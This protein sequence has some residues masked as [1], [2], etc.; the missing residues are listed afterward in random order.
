MTYNP[1]GGPWVAM[2]GTYTTFAEL[3]AATGYTPGT[4]AFA[5]DCGPVYS[6]GSNWHPAYSNLVY[7][8]GNTGTTPAP[9]CSKGFTQSW[10][11][12]GSVTWGAPTNTT[13]LNIGDMLTLAVQKDANGTARTTAWNAI[14]RNA[15]TIASTSTSGAKATFV[16][17]WDGT[18]WQYIGG[19]TA[20]A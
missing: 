10:T 13:G 1:K 19:S 2:L 6:D 5:Q 12:N 14:Y 18:S 15:P 17:M 4:M 16:Y 3:P 11:Q 8:A 7:S 9:D 20:F